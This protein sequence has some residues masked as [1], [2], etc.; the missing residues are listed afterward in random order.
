[1]KINVINLTKKLVSIPSFVD[2]NTNETKIGNFVVEFVE[3]NL[4]GIPTIKQYLTN[5]PNRFN[6][7]IGSLQP[8]LLVVGHLDTV[9]PQPG[10]KTNPLSASVKNNCLYGLGTSDMKGSMAA[11]LCALTTV[12]DKVNTSK[13]GV[14]LYCDEEYDFAGMKSFIQ[15]AGKTDPKIIISID[16]KLQLSSGC[17]GLVEIS[18]TIIGKSGHSSKP[19]T[20]LN[21]ITKT[22]DAIGLVDQNLSTYFDPLLGPTTTNL[23]YLNGGTSQGNIIPGKA[24]FIFEVRTS[25][26]QT[27]AAKAI[28][29]LKA[30]GRNLNVRFDNIKIRHDLNPW[31]PSYK[32]R[33]L[34]KFNKI[35]TR[36][37]LD[38]QPSSRFYS[39]Y[40]DA[41]MLES[42]YPLTPK[43]VFGAGGENQH[44][45]GEF[46]P[47]QNLILA[48][49]V[50]EQLLIELIKK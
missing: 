30:C 43:L 14:L 38:T 16:G 25:S 33:Y 26:P 23:A 39:G 19:F 21:A 27:N 13:L 4:G 1:M 44:S 17:R 11:F 35:L 48:Q 9:Q 50:Y 2:E 40:L 37:K 45:P 3:K 6:V 46:V 34:G 20:G 41:G 29:L 22:I 24:E 12:K 49:K 7:F 31:P 5:D 18:G 42:I 8:E 32:S 15:K 47:I 28:Q 10:W 36:F